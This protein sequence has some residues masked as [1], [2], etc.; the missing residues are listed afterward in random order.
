MSARVCAIGHRVTRTDDAG[1]LDWT[2]PCRRRPGNHGVRIPGEGDIDLCPE[3]AAVLL[4]LLAAARQN[5]LART[6]VDTS[7]TCAVG[8]LLQM[9]CG[10]PR[11]L[12]WTDPCDT[13][14]TMRVD[15]SNGQTQHFCR[16]H[17]IVV[18]HS[19]LTAGSSRA[20]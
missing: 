5:R 10:V 20:V 6:D 7:R 3:H 2:T 11:Q 4:P 19:M 16:P 8:R 9:D 17:G 13:P 12:N 15:M 1:G 18:F 14:P